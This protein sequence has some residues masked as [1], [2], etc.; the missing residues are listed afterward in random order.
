MLLATNR[1]KM[2]QGC[3]EY[4]ADAQYAAGEDLF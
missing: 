4:S 1:L 3:D 2:L